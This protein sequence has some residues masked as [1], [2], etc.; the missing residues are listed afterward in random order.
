M[1]RS[2]SVR[3]LTDPDPGVPKSFVSYGSGSRSPLVFFIT[4]N[5]YQV[6]IFGKLVNP[7]MAKFWTYSI[8]YHFH[9]HFLAPIFYNSRQLMSSS[10]V[11]RASDCWYL[12][13]NSPGF[14]TSLWGRQMKH[15]WINCMKKYSKNPPLWMLGFWNAGLF[16]SVVFVEYW[17]FV[18]A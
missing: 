1:A 14:D 16:L 11:V 4:S 9:C 13:R 10:R 17:L 7:E 12:S 3:I 5:A 15:C 8:S 18:N 6:Y 2:G